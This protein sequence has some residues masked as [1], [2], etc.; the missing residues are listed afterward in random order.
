MVHTCD[1]SKPLVGCTNV[2]FHKTAHANGVNVHALNIRLE[3]QFDRRGVTLQEEVAVPFP[4]VTMYVE[5]KTDADD[6][7]IAE[8]RRQLHMYCP[9]S[10]VIRASGTELEEVWTVRRP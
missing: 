8:A 1:L 7:K 9:V 5:L 3:S 4:K 2:I 10:K 6:A